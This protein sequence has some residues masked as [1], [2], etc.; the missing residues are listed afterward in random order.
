MPFDPGDETLTCIDCHQQFVFT[1]GEKAFFD[2]KGFTDKPKR[3]PPC[4][5]ARKA[6]QNQDQQVQQVWA[7]P[8]P[9]AQPSEDFGNSK[10]YRGRDRRSR[11]GDPDVYY[12]NGRGRRY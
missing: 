6:R 3:C 2:G 10:S 7:Q 8:P 5:K 1:A 4:R 9:P 12:N 11:G